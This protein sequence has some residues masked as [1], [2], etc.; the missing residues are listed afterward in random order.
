MRGDDPVPSVLVVPTADV[1]VEAAACELLDLLDATSLTDAAVEDRR[2]LRQ[3]ADR[4]RVALRTERT[5]DDGETLTLRE[6][7]EAL[8]VSH[9][10]FVI[11]ERRATAKPILGLGLMSYDEL[12]HR[13]PQVLLA[14]AGRAVSAD[15]VDLTPPA[16]GP[17]VWLLPPDD[18]DESEVIGRTPRSK[19]LRCTN[20][21][22]Q[23]RLTHY[24]D[25]R[26]LAAAEA[27]RDRLRLE[28][29]HWRDTHGH[30]ST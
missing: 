3:A 20:A 16:A 27:E 15:A 28:V 4:L 18:D 2:A 26:N 23:M 22:G 17:D 8:G 9:G 5:E 6:T 14:H 21:R 13:I 1:L 29:A 25:A 24:V 30:G 19:A 10:R 12:P 11:L 7:A